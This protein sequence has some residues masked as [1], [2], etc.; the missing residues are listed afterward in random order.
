MSAKTSYIKLEK[1]RLPHHLPLLEL[2]RLDSGQYIQEGLL[3]D[4]SM[5]YQEAHKVI[6][7]KTVFRNVVFTESSLIGSELTDV[8]FDKCDLS[9]A[10]F[11][12][13]II[14]RSEFLDCK[15]VGTNLTGATI[16]NVRFRQCL[17]DYATFRFSDMKSIILEECSLLK[18]DFYHCKLQKKAVFRQCNIDGAQFSGTELDGID[19]SDCQFD[20][21]GVEANNL[22]GCLIAREQ[23]YLFAGLFGLKLK[24]D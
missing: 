17:A 23:A 6:V 9:N 24:G 21:I 18:S 14:H 12:D 5:E 22:K 19:L 15:M 1:P 11:S 13:A 4:A 16:R 8:V 20:G 10:N 3:Q 7:D 2:D